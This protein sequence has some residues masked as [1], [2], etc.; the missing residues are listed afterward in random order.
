MA[1]FAILCTDK[2]GAL[3]LRLATREAHLAYARGFP[4]LIRL[5]G[6]FLNAAGEMTGSLFLVEAPDIDAVRAFN[7]ADPYTLAGLFERVEIT[8]WRATIGTLP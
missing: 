3:A 5:A 8:P 4:G 2:P 6:P 1:Q 7:A